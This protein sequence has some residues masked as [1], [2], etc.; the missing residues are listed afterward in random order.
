M[1][2]SRL[3][4]VGTVILAL[5]G[6]LNGAVVAQTDEV[7]EATPSAPAFYTC[8]T[9]DAG[10]MYDPGSSTETDYGFEV[11]GASGPCESEASDPRVSGPCTW[12]QNQDTYDGTPW[13]MGPRW[14]S[15]RQENDGG[16]WYGTY[17]GAMVPTASGGFIYVVVGRY[18]GTGGYEGLSQI[19]ITTYPDGPGTTGI[20][21]GVIYEG[22]LPTDEFVEPPPIE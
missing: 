8:V 5:T 21:Q 15:S 22:P 14:G 1:R 12:V 17:L 16:G 9:P 6:G 3:S 4:L 10:F 19:D 20:C 7:D 11:R 18:Q 2:T 13:G